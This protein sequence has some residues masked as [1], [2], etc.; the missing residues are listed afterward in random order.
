MRWLNRLPLRRK[1]MVII[2]AVS[3]SALL[4]ACI[5]I[6]AYD[7]RALR[8]NQ[9]EQMTT[10]ADVIGQNA[11]AALA[12]NDRAA[13]NEI[14]AGSRYVPSVVVSC[15][16][17]PDGSLFASYAREQTPCPARPR[18]VGIHH[19][20]GEVTLVRPVMVGTERVGTIVVH[21]HPSE[22]LR[23][24]RN[25]G[26]LIIFVLLGSSVLAL[27]LA[28]RLQHVITRPIRHLL[29]ITRA[30]SL[31]RGYSVRA[32][33]QTE[34]EFGELVGGFNDMLEQI[35]KRDGE[36]QQHRLHLEEEVSART[37]QL[38]QLNADLLV[39]KDAAEAASRAKSEFLANM[40]HEI[41]TPMN[42]VLGMLELTLDTALTTEQREYLQMAKTSG[43]SLLAITNDILDFSKIEAGKLD[44]EEV[45][46]DLHD[47]IAET[48]KVLALRAHQKGLELVCNLDSEVPRSVIGDSGRLRQV[49]INL[50]GNAIKFT[51]EGE[52]V[53]EVRSLDTQA[54][55]AQLLF[56]ISDTGAGIAAD[57][58]AVIFEAFAQ[59]DNSAT[60]EY[61]GTGLGL[62]I[63]SRLVGLMGGHISVESTLGR[64]STFRFTAR[65]VLSQVP[66]SAPAELF[67]ADLLHVPVLVVDDNA[68]NR[69]ILEEM[70]KG[71]GVDCHSACGGPEALQLMTDAQARG[72]PY[73]IVLLDCQMP[74]LDGFAVADVIRADQ[75]LTSTVIM[76]LT[77]ADR[78]GDVTRCRRLGIVGYL[79]KPIRRSE[80]LTALLRAL[81]GHGSTTSRPDSGRAARGHAEPRHVLVA[82]DNL[83]NQAYLCRTLQKLGHVT[84][85]AANGRETIE[86][87]RAGSFDLIFMDVQMPEMDGLSATGAIRE[88]EQSSGAHIPIFAM[89]AHA[90]K[91][92]RERCLAAGMD[93][94]ISKPATLAEIE[95]AVNSV[96]PAAKGPP[97]DGEPPHKPVLWDRA[98]ALERVG[99]D[100]SLLN[101]LIN[102][103][104]Q[105]YPVLAQRL[106]EGLSRGDLAA[107]REPAHSLKGSLG[108][109][110]MEDAA[111]LALEIEQA[112][113]A[114]D[115]DR[116]AGLIDTMMSQVS[117]VQ[118][119][120][121]TQVPE[122]T[123]EPA[124]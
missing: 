87:F 80:L 45:G 111:S 52:I 57:K 56:S 49:L 16:Y 44:L 123:L 79:V 62:A 2:V 33:S 97:D 98:A 12:F 6:I 85:T 35:Q 70:L 48:V 58:Q 11:S 5:A 83:V 106:T 15:L 60:R 51:A 55:W 65:I 78:S 68:T 53:V 54:T 27:L 46:F 1:L 120:M 42:G 90:L 47:L 61:G 88:L 22:L 89:T 77:S 36:L 86:R 121:R 94:Y 18:A 112:S 67:P 74:G 114:Q 41:R 81:A 82:E 124:T 31:N 10:L 69:R 101:E 17:L 39:A 59:A 23:R 13:A 34:D 92:D 95:S 32:V 104:L 73:R 113:R 117:A 103:F 7:L 91:G 8:D 26:V 29:T 25:Y 24:F 109:L 84:T 108:Y 4:L 64:G 72:R 37:A 50:V 116:V 66:F 76:M 21:C 19:F 3:G 122:K 63:S 93:G 38:H 119:A 118:Q 43:D 40:S 28:S 105:E 110:G 115:A 20:Q 30:V 9:I 99:G 100:E 71:W 107:L 75:S 102:I 14:L 96:P